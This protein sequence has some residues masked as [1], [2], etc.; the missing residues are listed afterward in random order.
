M[1]VSVSAPAADASAQNGK[2]RYI[3][4]SPEAV[5]RAFG[6]EVAAR[7]FSDAFTA[8]RQAAVQRSARSVPGF[9]CAPEPKAGLVDVV[10]YPVRPGA[11]SW[12]ESFL[13][14][15]APTTRRSFLMLADGDH[16][17]LAELLPGFTLTD[18][19][20]QRDASQGAHAY[21]KKLRPTGC[22]KSSIADTGV[23]ATPQ[24][25]GGFWVER[26]TLDLCGT[27]AQVEMTFVPSPK[28]GT[29]WSAKLI[30]S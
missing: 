24:E 26:W 13:V 1:A 20:L 18:P 4:A 10:P 17:R 9:E 30:G 16:V 23:I 21:A 11:V 7:I 14:H 3:K 2:P 8:M 29:S 15:C 19:L 6:T 12:V 27:R 28:G 5:T 25:K 22:E